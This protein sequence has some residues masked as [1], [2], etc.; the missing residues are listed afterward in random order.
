MQNLDPA[1]LDCLAALADDGSFERAAQRLSITQS[2]VS[3][4]LR[5]LE[6]QVGQLLVVRARPLRLTE[7]GKVLLRFARQLQAMRADVARELGER[8]QSQARLPIA[9]NADSLATWVLPALDE[10]VQQGLRDGFGLEL[11]VDDQD[12]THE[13]L[14]QGQV[15]GC[16]STVPQALRGCRVEPLGVMRYIAVASPGFVARELSGDAADGLHR[17]NFARVPFL[18]FNRKDDTQTQWVSR[19]FGVRSPRLEERFVPSSEAY[20]RAAAL[21]WGIGVVPELQVRERLAQGELLCLR[22]D[23]GIE[24]A[25]HWHQW[26]LGGDSGLPVR[27]ARLDEVGAALARGAA[28]ALDR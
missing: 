20:V 18:V 11:I 23:I 27:A 24:V 14:R 25:L 5:A 13:W 3:Q 17:G 19:A 2:A 26:K 22:P 28:Q 15:L 21:G 9:V 6:S 8:M 4:R 16:V 10:L 1:A 12:F 7:P